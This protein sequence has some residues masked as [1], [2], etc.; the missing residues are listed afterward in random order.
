MCY[1]EFVDSDLGLY[2][3][4]TRYYD[5][6]T[7]RFI[8]PD[9]VSYLGA[10]G[11]ILSYNLYAYC[12]NNPVMY[13]DPTGEFLLT[14]LLWGIG[15]GAAIGGAVGVTVAYKS[16]ADGWGIAAGFAKGA[17]VGAVVGGMIGSAVGVWGTYRFTSVVGTAMTTNTLNVSAIIAE[18]TFLQV[19]KSRMDGKQGWQVVDDCLDSIF[20]NMDAIV[21]PVPTKVGTTTLGYFAALGE[22]RRGPLSMGKYLKS[23]RN[24]IISY[25]GVAISVV[26]TVYSAFCND[27]VERARYRG[28][29]LR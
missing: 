16:G 7:G 24:N 23:S 28:Y 27:P 26:N 6:N 20:G 12:S 9:N 19:K 21:L 14:A 10:N 11:D 15:I 5:S 22:H 13:V 4:Q 17:V 8:S 18:V 29:A 2:Y 25:I 3:L 1:T